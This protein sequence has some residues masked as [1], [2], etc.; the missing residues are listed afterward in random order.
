MHR[1]FYAIR[2]S[3]PVNEYL[4]SIIEEL[5]GHHASV[6]W[7]PPQNIHLTLRFL[8][9]ITD[10]QL[11]VARSLPEA[12]ASLHAF[13]VRLHGLG[14]FPMMRSPRVLWAGIEGEQQTDT[15]H[16]FHLHGRTESWAREI[17]LQPENRRFSPHVTIGRVKQPLHNMRELMNDVISRECQSDFC[18]IQK[19]M[20]M[21]STLAPDGAVYDVVEAW[22]LE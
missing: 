15:D 19:L 12:D 22:T 7:V 9:E 3:D 8:G 10:E 4:A 21:R 13:T 16:L 14:S 18:P 2:L 6:R 1:C 17:G 5:K 11:E 20:L